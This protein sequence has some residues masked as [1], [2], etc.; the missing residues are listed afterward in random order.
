MACITYMIKN[1][2]NAIQFNVYIY[3]AHLMCL[4][5][6]WNL[7]LEEIK[8]I[9]CPFLKLT[10]KSIKMVNNYLFRAEWNYLMLT[11]QIIGVGKLNKR[12]NQWLANE[13][14]EQQKE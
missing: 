6:W 11:L 9:L 13:M 12:N 2:F 8:L 7:E 3:L 10:T 1:N 14:K 4:A 5:L